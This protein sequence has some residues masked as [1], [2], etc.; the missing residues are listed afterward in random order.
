MN[1]LKKIGI[2]VL[3]I[4]LTICIVFL[5]QL[6]SEQNEER[7]LNKKIQWDYNIRDTTIVTGKQVAELYYSREISI[8]VY[9]DISLDKDHYK[10]SL[11]QEKSFELFEAVFESDESICGH[12]KMIITDG[13]PHYSQSSTLIKIDNQPIAL[14]FIDVIITSSNDA[15][16]FVYEEKTKTLISFFCVSS[17]YYLSYQYDNKSFINSL[18][19]AVKDYYESK[20]EIDTSKYYYSNESVQKNDMK[21]YNTEF[22]IL[23]CPTDIKEN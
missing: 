1:K 10:L 22:G 15:I 5:P 14:N 6:I 17:S 23:Q 8:G 7:L 3:L 9:N 11:M 19:A 16:E 18:D 13:T 4:I 20:L 12:I 2:F 21:E